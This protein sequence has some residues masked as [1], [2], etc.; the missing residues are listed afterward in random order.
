MPVLQLLKAQLELEL[1]VPGVLPV[2][3]GVQTP[4]FYEDTVMP[5]EGPTRHHC[6]LILTCSVSNGPASKEGH[7]YLAVL[8]VC[9]WPSF[10]TGTVQ[11]IAEPTAGPGEGLFCSAP[12][13][14][15]HGAFQP[16]KVQLTSC[17]P[18]AGTEQTRPKSA[19]FSSNSPGS[20]QRG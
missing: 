7:S 10:L 12:A 4:T 2:Y 9:T 6:D 8:G 17:L 18:G 16:Q 3:G 13:G 14:S 11:T 15:H 19:L 5:D 20:I 1:R